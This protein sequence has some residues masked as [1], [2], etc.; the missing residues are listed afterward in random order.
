[1]RQDFTPI[2]TEA[3]QNKKFKLCEYY[4]AHV[5]R[6]FTLNTGFA[7][8]IMLIVISILPNVFIELELTQYYLT[9]PFLIPGLI[10]RATKVYFAYP[11]SLLVAA[12][13][14]NVILIINTIEQFSRWGIVALTL[15]VFKVQ[16]LG[17]VGIVYAL[18]L[19]Y[20]P[21]SILKAIFLYTYINKKIFHLQT[22]KW[23]TFGVPILTTAILY[24]TFYIMKIGILDHLWEWN[25][26]GTLVIGII[27]LIVLALGLYFPLTV[28]LGGWDDNSIRDFKMVYRMAGPSKFFVIP[29]AKLVFFTARH[30]PL[31]NKF[32]FD[33]PE[34]LQQVQEL[35]IMRDSNRAV[36]NLKNP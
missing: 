26:I 4:N 21:V 1:V 25:F 24:G 11:D 36:Q 34:A 3:Y 22:M 31:H 17:F 7:V 6:F 15:L 29:I 33:S 20:I 35:I 10:Y 23:Q 9:I 28:A 12:G 19:I 14:A 5:L 16:E 2:F 27:G 32:K 18:S 8:A 13:K 30:A